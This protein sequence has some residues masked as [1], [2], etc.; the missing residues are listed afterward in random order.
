MKATAE[1]KAYIRSQYNETKQLYT[2]FMDEMNAGTLTT[3]EKC[4]EY[5]YMLHHVGINNDDIINE[6]N[7]A[8]YR[9][10]DMYQVSVYRIFKRT[11]LVVQWLRLH[12]PNA[13]GS[14]SIPGQ[15]TRFHRLQLRL[16]ISYP[17]SQCRNHG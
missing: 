17:I 14:S 12:D 5:T 4:M 8:L 6:G 1:Y 10:M 2:Q 11:S 16:V 13:G 3:Y 9:V 15:G 7:H